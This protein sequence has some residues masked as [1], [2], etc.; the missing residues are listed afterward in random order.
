MIYS[1]H[2]RHS[3]DEIEPRLRDAAQRH[4]FG[5]LHVHDLKATLASKGIQF[6]RECRVFDVCNPEA[7]SA[8]LTQDTAV[9]VVLPCRISVFS[10]EDGSRIATLK[11]TDLLKATGLEGVEGIAAEVERE[12]QAIID[13]AA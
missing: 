4:K 13:E 3:P 9:S 1:R 5:V 6:G 7:A 11:A 10:E 12:I 2:S 8:A